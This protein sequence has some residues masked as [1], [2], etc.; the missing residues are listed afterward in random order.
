MY[1]TVYFHKASRAAEVMLRLIFKRFKQLIEAAGPG[2]DIEALAPGAPKSVLAAF[3]ETPPLAVYLALDDHAMTDLFKACARGDDPL[4]GE[5]GEGLLNRRLYKSV[6]VTF[7]SP[8]SVAEFS[9]AATE[10]ISAL[11][12]DPTYAFVGDSPGDTPY[13]PYDPDS[14]QASDQILVEGP[15]VGWQEI[16]QASHSID[17]IQ[18]EYR[19]LRYYFPD[20][21]R[22]AVTAVAAA[23]LE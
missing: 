2:A 5:L 22:D 11:G 4:L 1:R 17:T 16:S 9:V 8:E 10:K 13:R 3:A 19:L 6:E 14:A 20:R 18:K 12:L 23:L 21:V 15:T 7:A